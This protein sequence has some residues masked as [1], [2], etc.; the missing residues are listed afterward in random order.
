MLI[1]L[2]AC[3]WPVEIA[4]RL[5]S[6]TTLTS[7]S[8]AS[9]PGPLHSF[10]TRPRDQ[11][12]L[13]NTARVSETSAHIQFRPRTGTMKSLSL[14]ESLLPQPASFQKKK[15]YEIHEVLG[16]GTFGKVMV[17]IGLLHVVALPRI[18]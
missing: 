14:A 9:R 11:Q 12:N 7:S 5:D 18:G 2:G 4:W 16:E 3:A 6:A 8:P 13:G 10:Q 15:H 17:R 1:V